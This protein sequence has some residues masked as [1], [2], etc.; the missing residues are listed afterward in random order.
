MLQKLRDLTRKAIAL[1]ISSSVLFSCGPQ[2]PQSSNSQ[3]TLTPVQRQIEQSSQK[4][5]LI[6]G[7]DDRIS[8]A[9]ERIENTKV[10]QLRILRLDEKGRLRP[11]NTVC[12]A[13]A[14]GRNQITT[15]GHCWQ[16]EEN[17]FYIF[18]D[19]N[20]NVHRVVGKV[21]EL[22]NG[23]TLVLYTPDISQWIDAGSL[24]ATKPVSMIS[25]S[26]DRDAL[27]EVLNDKPLQLD[28][29][30]NF[31]LSEMDS[32]PGASGSPILQDGK[33]VAVHQGWVK[34]DTKPRTKKNFAALVGIVDESRERIKALKIRLESDFADIPCV[35]L[36]VSDPTEYKRCFY[37]WN[38]ENINKQV[39]NYIAEARLDNESSLE[40][41][42]RDCRVNNIPESVPECL[43]D[44]EL[45]RAVELAER[46]KHLEDM[47]TEMLKRAYIEYTGSEPPPEGDEDKIDNSP[48][49]NLQKA[50]EK[51]QKANELKRRTRAEARAAA[52]QD[53]AKLVKKALPHTE[54]VGGGSGD[55]SKSVLKEYAAEYNKLQDIA[56]KWNNGKL[57]VDVDWSAVVVAE[58]IAVLT[59][60]GPAAY[61]AALQKAIAVLIEKGEKAALKNLLR[62]AVVA[63]NTTAVAAAAY[64][65]FEVGKKLEKFIPN[66]DYPQEAYDTYNRASEIFDDVNSWVKNV[67]Q[68]QTS[69][70]FGEEEYDDSEKLQNESDKKSKKAKKLKEAAKD[71][72]E[73]VANGED[74]PNNP[75]FEGAKL[76]EK[77]NGLTRGELHTIKDEIFQENR[78]I[79]A[80]HGITNPDIGYDSKGRL[81]FRDRTKPNA[82]AVLGKGLYTDWLPG[83][84]K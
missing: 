22:S 43:N 3:S 76:I 30:G 13:F 47:R 10:G 20:K 2:F 40:I 6:F 53:I 50:R 5:N 55:G 14:S 27:T 42:R 80:K 72:A 58:S 62:S 59:T 64:V 17:K 29:S 44:L 31:L 54:K 8:V 9:K 35:D 15:A 83:G 71:A 68:S 32:L 41:A 73:D 57:P 7:Q 52:A 78:D 46:I 38:V 39:D 45:H 49:E 51:R 63:G 60:E 18:M 1:T 75:T 21:P 56:D 12:T 11:T 4:I 24:D 67:L 48:N 37:F 36:I 28:P 23:N 65:G 33:V 66:W 19:G 34:L 81:T 26:K 69:A 70:D 77:K 25:Y 84:V 82:P 61:K 79:L 16:G 74:K